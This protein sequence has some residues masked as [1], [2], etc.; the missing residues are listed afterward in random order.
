MSRG[1]PRGRRK[2]PGG[3]YSERRVKTRWI[4]AP[5][6]PKRAK[7]AYD[8][9]TPHGAVGKDFSPRDSWALHPGP[10]AAKLRVWGPFWRNLA[11][12]APGNAPWA[13][14]ENFCPTGSGGGPGA[15][16]AR[17][18]GE[19]GRNPRV[20]PSRPAGSGAPK[21]PIPGRRRGRRGR[22]GPKGRPE[23][24]RKRHGA[25]GSP[26]GEHRVGASHALA[27]QVAPQGAQSPASPRGEHRVGASHPLAR[28][29][30]RSLVLSQG[31]P[32]PGAY[33]R[34]PAERVPARARAARAG[35]HPDRWAGQARAQEVQRTEAE[36]VRGAQRCGRDQGLRS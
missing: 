25:P 33:A 34:T 13:V 31:S 4:R 15:R 23:W 12:S 10:R 6:A 7:N 20:F 2:A 27:P 28:E 35:N 17:P 8:R 22:P 11:G 18:G 29:P 19:F 9:G 32:F 36:M 21:P 5:G 26:R 24:R 30:K 16:F 14:G 3:G 1:A